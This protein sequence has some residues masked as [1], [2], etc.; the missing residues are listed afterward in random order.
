MACPSHQIHPLLPGLEQKTVLALPR[1]EE[2]QQWSMERLSTGGC[3]C[4]HLK[5]GVPKHSVFLPAM[6]PVVGCSY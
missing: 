3:C 2:M 5:H 1:V 4:M 6:G